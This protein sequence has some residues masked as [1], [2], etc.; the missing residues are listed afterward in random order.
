MQN[1]EFQGDPFHPSSPAN[2]A[3]SHLLCYNGVSLTRWAE[4]TTRSAFVTGVSSKG[5]DSPPCAEGLVPGGFPGSRGAASAVEG[6]L[7]LAAPGGRRGTLGVVL[8]NAA[9]TRE[10]QGFK[11]DRA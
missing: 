2:L 1:S 3:K 11:Q 6:L 8:R 9:A 5:E 4:E 10:K 7:L